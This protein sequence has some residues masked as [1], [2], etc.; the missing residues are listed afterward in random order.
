MGNSGYSKMRSKRGFT[1]IELMIVVTII[2]ILAAI[3]IPAY[4]DYVKRSRMSE[5][6]TALDAIAQGAG[7]YHSAVGHFPAAT[8]GSNNLAY[9]AQ[10]YANVYLDEESNSY[11]SLA[12]VANFKSTLDLTDIDAGTE[13]ELWMLITYN[14][15]TGYDK[16]WSLS[17]TSIDAVYIPK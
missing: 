11:Y 14:E 3:A 6:L 4:R 8:Y 16:T 7:E 2:G 10:L 9:F 15:I 13:G 5:V 1:L 12:L 17:N